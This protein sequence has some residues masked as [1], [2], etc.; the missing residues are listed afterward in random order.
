[1][2]KI[3]F[4]LH[5]TVGS[6]AGVVI[7]LM[8]VTGVLLTYEKQ[9]TAWVDR[10]YKVK[11]LPS[12][13]SVEKVLANVRNAKAITIH[14]DAGQPV[15]VTV[16]PDGGVYANPYTGEIIGEQSRPA[17]NFFR[18]VT[19]WHRWLGAGN[20]G[21]TAISQ[22]NARVITAACNLAFLGLI[23]SGLYLWLPRV[24]RWQNVR[25]AL[26]FRRGLS[27]KA[28]NFNWHN[29]AGFW[30]SVPLFFVVVSSV[31]MSYPWASNLVYRA[32]GS[33]PPAQGE[34]DGGRR[35][36]G[37][38]KDADF[39]GFDQLWSRAEEQAR[40]NVPGWKTI[41][42]RISASDR[43]P[44]AFTI[45]ASDGGQPQK[46]ATLTLNRRTG[47]VEKWEPFSSQDAGRRVRT[48]FRFTHTGE[49]YG[50][51]GQT[52]AGIASAG[53][54]LLVWT[55]LSLALRRLRVRLS[56]KRPSTGRRARE[57]VAAGR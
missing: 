11:P 49:Y 33:P 34:R 9:V 40:T 2:R 48:W 46:R 29:T 21:Q 38:Q 3:F 47:E 35:G 26:W 41:N 55:G 22:V 42:V 32:A 53:G 57:P 39:L 6:L 25:A 52:I 20:G 15:L 5:L 13:R 7:L 44:V 56:R 51:V 28:R 17:Q 1:M 30:C 31:V 8:S 27:G 19:A 14:S 24:W 23:M 54:A 43:A 4:W 45:D 18:V 10:D 16:N 36:S 50:I 37:S 12:P